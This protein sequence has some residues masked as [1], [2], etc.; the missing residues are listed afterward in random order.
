MNKIDSTILELVEDIKIE[1]DFN[2]DIQSNETSES[3]KTTVILT[4]QFLFL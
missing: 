4:I 3:N 1:W 2:I